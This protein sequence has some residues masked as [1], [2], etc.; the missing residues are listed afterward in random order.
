[1]DVN[2]PNTKK[3]HPVAALGGI[4]VVMMLIALD[5]T[6]VGTALPQ[7]VSD[8]QGFGLYPWVAAAYLLTNAIFIPV[9]G[10]LGDLHGRKPFLL[11]AIALLPPPRCCADWP[12]ACCNWC[13]RGGCRG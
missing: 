4:A 10:R 12:T 8:L 6:V 13:W 2:L 11:V 9:T 7:M 1:M 3:Q 5:Q